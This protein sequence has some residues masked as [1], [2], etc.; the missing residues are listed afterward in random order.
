[1]R[2][3]S[4]K[5]R[6]RRLQAPPG[7]T[8]RPTSD[9]VREAIFNM[10]ASLDALEDATVV[11]LFAGTGGLGIEALSRGAATVTFVDHDA[12][13]IETVR[14]N[15][16]GTGLA[17][18]EAVVVR[19]D[20]LRWL[21]TAGRR[22]LAFADP[23]YAFDAWPELLDALDADVA[24]LESDREIDPGSRFDVLRSRRYGSTVVTV[25]QTTNPQVDD[26]PLA[27]P[28]APA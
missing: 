3:V 16:A 17:G 6:G 24:V 23:P 2:V 26:D 22:D 7:T 25:L 28:R 13:A 15:L 12:K 11:D 10:L 4:G 8:I 27:A 9:R 20:V 18:P 1:M 5:A 19:G 21:A 14:A